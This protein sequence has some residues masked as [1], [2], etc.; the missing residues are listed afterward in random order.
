MKQN[1]IVSILIKIS[2]KLIEYYRYLDKKT[3]TF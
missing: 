1:Y 2:L 3:T